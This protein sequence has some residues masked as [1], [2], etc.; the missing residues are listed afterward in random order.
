MSA[1]RSMIPDPNDYQALADFLEP[2]PARL[3]TPKSKPWNDDQVLDYILKDVLAYKDL[4]NGNEH[5]IARKL[6]D[7]YHDVLGFSL[8]TEEDL[9]EIRMEFKDNSMSPGD[10]IQILT[11]VTFFKYLRDYKFY[12]IADF[13]SIWQTG[14]INRNMF[15]VFCDLL[16]RGYIVLEKDYQCT[17]YYYSIS[18]NIWIKGFGY[19]FVQEFDEMN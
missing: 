15:Y 17:C 16:Q 9:Q 4:P 19:E 12:G 18:K 13:P 8:A 11:F 10:I 1:T 7:V 2:Y 5:P 3:P 14:M 6:R